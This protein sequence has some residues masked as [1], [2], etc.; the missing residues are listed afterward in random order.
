MREYSIG[1]QILG[2]FGTRCDRDDLYKIDF[3]GTSI[4]DEDLALLRQ[5]P[6]LYRL[7]LSGTK[8]TDDGLD[9]VAACSTLYE[10]NLSNTKVTDVGALNLD[11]C[12]HSRG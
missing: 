11:L 7:N 8:V 5:L 2:L 6:Y 10:L 1:Q 3:S 12:N 4:V 9:S